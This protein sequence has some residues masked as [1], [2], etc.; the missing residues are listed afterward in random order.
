MSITEIKKFLT[1]NSEEKYRDF[2]F[3]LIKKSDYPLIGVRL[4]TLK[5]LANEI[6]CDGCGESFLNEC[7]FSSMEMLFLYSYVLGKIKADIE[8]LW[9]YFCKAA[10]HTDNWSTCDIL[11][12]SFK[13]C[14]KNKDF[15]LEKLIDFLESGKTYYM[16]IAVVM[17]MTYYLTDEYIDTVLSLADKY[18]N[19]G[20][21]YKMGVAWLTA[22]SLAKQTEKTLVFMETCTLDDVTY[23]KAI[24]KAVESRR[25][26]DELKGKLKKMKRK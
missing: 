11:C 20:Y 9:R 23:N 16:R 14:E 18:K 7:D 10:E 17:L 22:T 1:E 3:G 19:D 21:Y 4:P 25:I 2:S 13:Q 6:C 24:Q 5:R 8:V 15:V 26:T 12:Q